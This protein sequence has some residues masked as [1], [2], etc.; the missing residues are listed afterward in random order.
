MTSIFNWI[1]HEVLQIISEWLRDP[2]LCSNCYGRFHY[3]TI[4]YLTRPRKPATGSAEQVSSDWPCKVFLCYYTAFHK[5]LVGIIF[6][7]QYA[8]PHIRDEEVCAGSWI[9]TVQNNRQ[10]LFFIHAHRKLDTQTPSA[11]WWHV[12]CNTCVGSAHA[13]S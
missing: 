5:A 7:L 10:R 11:Y 9:L 2:C 6:Y 4:L 13:E 8:F 3:G 12:T 1:Y